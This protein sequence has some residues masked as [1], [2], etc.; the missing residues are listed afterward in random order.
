MKR[1]LSILLVC[2]VILSAAAFAPVVGLSSDDGTVEIPILNG[3]FEQSPAVDI[4]QYKYEHAIPGWEVEYRSMP[5]SDMTPEPSE[6]LFHQIINGN[7]KNGTGNGTN[8]AHIYDNCDNNSSLGDYKYGQIIMASDYIELPA[9]GETTAIDYNLIFDYIAPD[10]DK[11]NGQDLFVKGVA[12][13]WAGVIFYNDSNQFYHEKNG[14]WTTVPTGERPLN[15]QWNDGCRVIYQVSGG[16]EVIKSG[17][18][19]TIQQAKTAPVGATKA[20]ILFNANANNKFDFAVDNVRF[21]YSPKQAAKITN[22]EFEDTHVIPGWSPYFNTNF[23]ANEYYTLS[24]DKA[25]DGSAALGIHK[26]VTNKGVYIYSDPILLPEGDKTGK[27][28]QVTFDGRSENGKTRGRYVLQFYQ[29]GADGIP[30]TSDDKVLTNKGTGGTTGIAPAVY[31]SETGELTGGQYLGV[32]DKYALSGT[33]N[34]RFAYQELTNNWKTYNYPV[35]Y[36]SNA[37]DYDYVRMSFYQVVNQGGTSAYFDNLVIEYGDDASGFAPLS[38]RNADFEE[39]MEVPGW[40][41]YNGVETDGTIAYMASDDNKLSGHLS[42][43]LVDKDPGRMI[44]MWSE[45]ID[46]ISGLTYNLSFRYN[47]QSSLAYDLKFFNATGQVYDTQRGEFVNADAAVL[48]EQGSVESVKTGETADK[49]KEYLAP[50]GA[51]YARIC[52]NTVEAGDNS[53]SC[54]DKVELSSSVPAG[55]TVLQPYLECDGERVTDMSV[56]SAGDVVQANVNCYNNTTE[57]VTIRLILVKYDAN[58]ALES[59]QSKPAVLAGRD[60]DAVMNEKVN[61]NV[62]ME[63]PSEGG[64]IKIFVWDSFIGMNNMVNPTSIT[65]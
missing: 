61:A 59:I 1:T 49:S 39:P 41:V 60:P 11:S 45:P 29:N 54:F 48:T 14:V 5:K 17:E 63:I 24:N 53:T 26:D 55:L 19:G 21:T 6:K 46:V 42:L 20:R 3:D 34:Y 30:G 56:L 64:S 12:R 52:F 4:S 40:S 18:W 62:Q 32:S 43:K 2:T 23:D 13:M 58:G 9:L 37:G 7:S 35:K 51:A 25:A 65:Y 44:G 38:I 8:V 36:A 31:N 28:F 47:V 22:S 57:D 50:E 16:D 27:S 33:D 10:Y 15:S